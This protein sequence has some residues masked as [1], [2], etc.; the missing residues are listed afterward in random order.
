M[1]YKPKYCADCGERVERT[2]WKPWSSRRF[3][4][5]CEED[6]RIHDLIPRLVLFF[7][8]VAG[9]F[10]LGVYM[11]KPEKPLSITRTVN[12]ENPAPAEPANASPRTLLSKPQTS[13]EP[14]K[15][16]PNIPSTPESKEV[17]PAP[18]VQNTGLEGVSYCG[19]RTKKGTPCK[20]LVKGTGKCWQH[21]IKPAN[22]KPGKAK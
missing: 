19:A 7:G 22:E 13:K 1:L 9:I 15:D 17:A 2:D 6:N 12:A 10:G 16:E 5:V 21:E 4:R 18:G 14:A 20:R 11:Q 8:A 3:C